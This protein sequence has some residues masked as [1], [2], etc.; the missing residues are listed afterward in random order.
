MVFIRMLWPTVHI[1]KFEAITTHKTGSTVFI[2]C[3]GVGG[4][5]TRHFL[6]DFRQWHYAS[7]SFFFINIIAGRITRSPV[8]AV[9][10]MMALKRPK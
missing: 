1:M 9:T 7:L 8:K 4:E 3:L 6:T 2:R 5:A 10:I